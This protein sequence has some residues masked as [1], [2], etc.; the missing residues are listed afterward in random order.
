MVNELILVLGGARSGKSEF[1]ES[2]YANTAN[3]YYIATGVLKTH[4]PEMQARIQKHQQRRPASWHTFEQ[5]QGLETLIAQHQVDGYFVDDATML[6]T[7]LFYDQLLQQ[8]TAS[9]LDSYLAQMS[10]DQL[11]TIETTILNAWQKILHARQHYQQSM[12][13]V[14]NEVGLGVVPATKQTRVLRD[15]YGKVNQLLAQQATKVYFV[16]SGIATQIK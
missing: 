14:S 12:V 8:T 7:D 13:I 16:I 1:A 3:I 10:A 9:E 5:Y 15:I 4:D 6:V 2:L 11:L